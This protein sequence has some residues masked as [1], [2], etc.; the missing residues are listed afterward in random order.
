[1]VVQGL[2]RIEHVAELNNLGVKDFQ[3][4]KLEMAEMYFAK[5]IELLKALGGLPF[6][7]I[8]PVSSDLPFAINSQIMNRSGPFQREDYDEG[9]DVFTKA[10]PITKEDVLYYEHLL[11]IILFNLGN[12]YARQRLE[13]DAYSLFYES[14]S[15]WQRSRLCFEGH[16]CGIILALHNIGRI[17]Y[18]TGLYSDAVDTYTQALAVCEA[19]T[20]EH[21]QSALARAATLNCLSVIIFHLP[22]CDTEKALSF[23]RNSLNLY[24]SIHGPLALTMEMATVMNNMGR[25]HFLRNEFK[26][27]LSI[28][29]ETLSMR[30][31]IMGNNNMDVAATIFNIA[32]TSHCLCNYERALAFYDEFLTIARAQ[33]GEKHR[34]IVA[35]IKVSNFTPTCML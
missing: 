15:M 35:A 33:L 27:A 24:R 21:K 4:D 17:E 10:V 18:R 26:Q 19:Y 5:A 12:C 11:A 6:S 34:D 28:Y 30:R 25:I 31:Q 7:T 16:H 23:C 8:S 32:Q 29:M 22:E 1:M 13:R 3:S 20:M 14:L 2:H 9:M